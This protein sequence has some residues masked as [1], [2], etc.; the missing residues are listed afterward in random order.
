MENLSPEETIKWKSYD[1]DHTPSG[2]HGIR[3]NVW[4]IDKDNKCQ[5]FEFSKG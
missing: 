3:A 5:K 1:G 4:L 2:R